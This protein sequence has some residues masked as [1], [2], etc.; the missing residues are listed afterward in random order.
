M[1]ETE[2]TRLLIPNKGTVDTAINRLLEYLVLNGFSLENTK[3]AS[4]EL[5]Q[6]YIEISNVKKIPIIFKNYLEVF[7]LE[8]G[9]FLDNFYRYNFEQYFAQNSTQNPTIFLHETSTNQFSIN[10]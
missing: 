8:H 7:G 10:E 1:N 2:K 9:G 5:I 3:G 4:N 6:K